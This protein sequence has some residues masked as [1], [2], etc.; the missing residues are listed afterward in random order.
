MPDP[1]FGA[2]LRAHR[3]AANLTLEALGERSGVSPRTISDM[4]R[5][6]SRGPQARTVEALADALGLA[7]DEREA[8][9]VAAGRGR[10]RPQPVPTTAALP[11]VDELFV[12]RDVERRQPDPGSPG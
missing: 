11:N 8:L 5:G 7:G 12:G 1:D 4:E 9:V 2:Q 10:V 3:H 6:R